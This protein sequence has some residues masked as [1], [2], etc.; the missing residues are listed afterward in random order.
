MILNQLVRI[1]SALYFG[2]Y[3]MRYGGVL[4]SH[5]Q[6]FEGYGYKPLINIK[7]K[8]GPYFACNMGCELDLKKEK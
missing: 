1:F 4:R 5:P 8:C 2:E 7:R 6:S 3:K